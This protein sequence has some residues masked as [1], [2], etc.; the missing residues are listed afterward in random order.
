M[1]VR[2]TAHA[3]GNPIATL[4]TVEQIATFN[5]V[6]IAARNIVRVNKDT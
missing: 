4:S 1:L 2:D 3:T 5:D 6:T